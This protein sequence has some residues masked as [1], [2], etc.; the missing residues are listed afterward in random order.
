VHLLVVQEGG[1]ELQEL[2]LPQRQEAV[3]RMELQEA[4]ALV[5]QM[6]LLALLVPERLLV[7]L[8]V[9]AI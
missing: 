5:Q 8:V 7:V 1:A 4:Q 6:E 2:S 3:Q 9:L